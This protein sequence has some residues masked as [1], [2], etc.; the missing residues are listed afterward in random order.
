MVWERL[1]MCASTVC[2]IS[3]HKLYL[4]LIFVTAKI[5]TELKEEVKPKLVETEEKAGE[6]KIKKEI[7]DEDENDVKPK[8]ENGDIKFNK[9]Q[10]ITKM[11][12]PE[13]ITVQDILQS[14]EPELI[15]LQMPDCLPGLKPEAT[16]GPAKPSTSGLS[17]SLPNDTTQTVASTKYCTL[18]TLSEGCIGK[19]QLLKSGRAR[20]VLGNTVLH[21]AMGTQVGFREDL[22]SVDLDQSTHGGDMINLGPVTAHLVCSPDWE[23]MLTKGIA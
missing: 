22:I 18:S 11:K 19:L 14:K 6:I 21:V 2:R 5:K 20:L 10:D 3:V 9:E 12:N 23:T 15:F 7:L 17:Q 4:C 16:T 13:L 1:N 8:I